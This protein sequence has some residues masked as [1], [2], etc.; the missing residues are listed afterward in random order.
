MH[1]GILRIMKNGRMLVQLGLIVESPNL[2]ESWKLDAFLQC[3][4]KTPFLKKNT[5]KYALFFFNKNIH[6]IKGKRQGERGRETSLYSG[7]Q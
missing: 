3:N 2:K 4:F 1:E 6:K 7:A 5:Q